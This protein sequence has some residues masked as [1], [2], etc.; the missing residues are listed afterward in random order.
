MTIS[1]TTKKVT[2]SG[3]DSATSF[4]F[5]P[6]TVF[7]TSDLLV[8]HVTA[9]G[10][11][12]T[13]TEGTGTTNYSVTL[14]TPTSLPSSGSITYPATLGT[15]LA[16]GD[17]IV[18]KRVVDLLQDVDLFN[19]GGFF[20][21]VLEG[22]LDTAMMVDLQQQDDIDRSLKGPI[23]D[24][25]SVE[26]PSE[27]ARASKFLT[28]DASGIPTVSAGSADSVTVTTFMATVLD[29]TTAAAARTTLGVPAAASS[30]TSSAEGLVELATTSE[31]A[32]GTDATRAVT[33]EG[34]HDMT[35][36]SGAAW[37]LD[38]DTLSSDSD[39]K[40]PS[41]QS[42]K[43][44]VDA[45]PSGGFTLATPQATTSGTSIDFTSIPAGTKTITVCFNGVSTSG[46]SDTIIQLGDSGGVETSGYSGNA[47]DSAQSGGVAS[48]A[49]FILNNLQ[50]AG[51]TMV[52]AV[53]LTLL[54]SSSFIWVMT[55]TMSDDAS[56]NV[57]W[58]S[59]DKTLSAELDRVRLTT[60]NGTDT[61][62]AGSVNILYGS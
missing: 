22:A 40:V 53:T 57:F 55:S 42:V 11:E 33:P 39:V 14:T 26:I 13:L 24:T 46:T 25:V 50:A 2:G 52:G 28:F 18:I 32:T 7:L 37:F 10:V 56:T 48:S 36:L 30:A 45:L 21:D 16:T 38:E 34:L 4:S 41:Q 19:Q 15:E 60:V 61:F 43:A 9:A 17:S 35:T 58:S 29:D 31:T 59:G 47:V 20:P 49:G 23:T 6:F 54:N 5:S 1:T 62:D 12:T 3:N 44:Y 8:V 51:D 27:T